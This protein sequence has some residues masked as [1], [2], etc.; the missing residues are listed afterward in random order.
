MEAEWKSKK[1]WWFWTALIGGCTALFA[2]RPA[3]MTEAVSKQEIRSGRNL[4]QKIQVFTGT[5]RMG[6]T[7]P[8]ATVP[9]GGVQVVP[10]TAFEP[11]LDSAG[12]YNPRTYEYCAGY[13]YL[14]S[15]ILGF[16]HTAFSGTGHSDLGDFLVMPV[17]GQVNLEAPNLVSGTRSLASDFRKETERAEPG[18]YE[19]KL[20]RWGVKSE[21][22]ATSRTGVHRHSYPA[23]EDAGL[24]LD[25][26]YNIYHHDSKNLWTFLRVENDSTLTGWRMTQ[27]W[28]RTRRMYFAMRLS[29]PL[30]SWQ[31]K[32]HQPL[33]YNGFYRRFN[34]NENFKEFA[35]RD[36]RM[37]MNFGEV[38]Q[39]EVRM[40]L[41]AVDAD[42]ALANLE[43]ESCGKSFDH[44]RT[45]AREHWEDALSIIDVETLTEADATTF[46]T[47]MYH[48]LLAPA[49]YEDVD[50]RYRG[51]D[52]RIHTSE[53]FSNH[54]VFSLWD[55]FRALHPW[56]TLMYPSRSTD[57]VASMLA[58][59]EESVHGMLPIWS[60]H[61]N[62]NWCMIGYHAASVL[63]DAVAK[64]LPVSPQEAFQAAHQTAQVRYFDG[65]GDY[66]DFGFVPDNRSHSAVS[67]TLELAYDDWCIAQ[68]A[69]AAGE[70]EWAA[71][72]EK[73]A[74]SYRSQWDAETG[75]MRPKLEDGTFRSPFDPLDTHGQGFIEGN[76]WTYSLFAPHAISDLIALHGGETRF[77]SHLDSLFTMELDDHYFAETED[78]TRDG[79]LG[80]YVHGN[81]P[82]HHIPYLFR[83]AGRSDRTDFWVR[84]ICQDM[85]GPGVDGLC[86]NDDAGQMS[87][88][89]LFSALG[90]YPVTP[91]STAYTLGSPSVVSADL[92]LE[93]GLTLSIRTKNQGPK[94]VYVQ[95]VMWND[96]PWTSNTI[97]HSQLM[98]GGVLT[99]ILGES[100]AM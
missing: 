25:L 42:G 20:E 17:V 68:L 15:T 64:S 49:V 95:K 19:V 34:E 33:A 51:V 54:T 5:S 6:H 66:I 1:T 67:K 8:G 46:R 13:Q 56:M 58:H 44:L 9:W 90:F 39:V 62:E 35:G 38:E 18:Y 55:T 57:F 63:A 28:A 29:Q 96:Q 52:D 4:T 31:F 43:A 83:H 98:A 85:Y 45:K 84:K 32:R 26:G 75:F 94:A 73:R 50:G 92:H 61:G 59:A 70:S 11:V 71:H 37:W 82:G 65:L 53:A 97:E 47:A 23:D 88:W 3:E 99:F 30:K 74:E 78:I 48:T 100:P 10:Q 21:L 12:K 87:A 69:R 24:V 77:V 16:A 91:G 89:Y 7:H 41:S 40:A 22:T 86:G 27:G 60:H 72:Y 93:N 2:C 14:D 79:I 80:N 81:E 36:V 76:A